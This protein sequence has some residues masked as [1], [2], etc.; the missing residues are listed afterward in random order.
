MGSAFRFLDK[1]KGLNKFG[2]QK[3]ALSFEPP[4]ELTG[5]N[6]GIH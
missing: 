4:A 2:L 1:N 6:M 3:L 5:E